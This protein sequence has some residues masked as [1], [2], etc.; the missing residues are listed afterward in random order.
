[1]MMIVVIVIASIIQVN[2]L[3]LTLHG[4]GFFCNNGNPLP[5]DISPL[6]N[7]LKQ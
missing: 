5:V 6:C 3:V 4:G 7:L 1:M 2:K